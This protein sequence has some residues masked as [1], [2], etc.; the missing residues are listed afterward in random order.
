[1]RRSVHLELHQD[2]TDEGVECWW[3][4]SPDFPGFTAAADTKKALIDRAYV[5]IKEIIAQE[6]DV[7]VLTWTEPHHPSL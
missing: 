6:E 4:D 7:L 3:A 1:M 2:Y 5:V